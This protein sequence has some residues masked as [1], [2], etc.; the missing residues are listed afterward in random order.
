MTKSTDLLNEVNGWLEIKAE[1]NER[2]FDALAGVLVLL[3]YEHRVVEQLLKL[4]IRVVDA[5]LLKRVELQCIQLTSNVHQHS[6]PFTPMMP[7]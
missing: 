3:Q 5:Q 2:P 1:V 6:Q 4:L 7:L